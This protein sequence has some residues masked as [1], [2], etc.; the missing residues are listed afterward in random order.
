MK[1]LA[2]TNLFPSASNPTRGAFNLQA[3]QALG[4]HV[5]LRV[6]VPTPW[7]ERIRDPRALVAVPTEV[8]SGLWCH[9]PTF[10][11]TPKIAAGFQHRLM[12]ASLLRTV[13]RLRETF[14]FEAVIS[15]W[16]YPDGAAGAR[17]AE[18]YGLSSVTLVLGSDINTLAERS[19]VRR[20]VAAGLRCSGRIVAVS[21]ALADRVASL[22]I[23]A[24]RIRVQ[25][26]GVD[27]ERFAP[28]SARAARLTLG[29]DS[30]Q[31][32]VVCVGNLAPEKGQDVLIRALA[33]ISAERR[34]HAYL[35]GD[36]T[37]R[38]SLEQLA[39]NLGVGASVHFTGR[40]PH[41]EIPLWINAA[42]ALCLPSRREGC[43]NVVLEAL[44]SGRPVVATSVGGVPEILQPDCGICVEP[45]HSEALGEAILRVLDRQYD[46]A[47]LRRSVPCL[48][49]EAF[50]RSLVSD[51]ESL[52][53]GCGVTASGSTHPHLASG[54]IERGRTP[55]SF[56]KSSCSQA[57][58]SA[59]S[60]G[61]VSET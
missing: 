41:D 58:H 55:Q 12:E 29:L 8:H 5:E 42:R 60:L 15:A 22:G 2:I 33:R 34:P 13:T 20:S 14:P 46:E 6:V 31:E 17:I 19:D 61:A 25:H 39:H 21:H 7:K 1:V 10:W 38:G 23:D 36:G 43:P 48:S 45:N 44:A 26:N 47:L 18:S 56:G 4:K 35:V 59:S 53:A 16:A 24:S 3:F 9:Y 57:T 50:G 30:D 40:R 51:L 54:G 11:N 37:T 27:G 32:F 49:W 52:D 28:R